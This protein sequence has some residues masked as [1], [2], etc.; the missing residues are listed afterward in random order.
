MADPFTSHSIRFQSWKIKACFRTSWAGYVEAMS[1]KILEYSRTVWAGILDNLSPS[2]LWPVPFLLV[3]LSAEPW[4]VTNDSPFWWLHF[5]CTV[6]WVLDV[7]CPYLSSPLVP[8]QS[9]AKHGCIICGG[10]VWD[11]SWARNPEWPQVTV[12]VG[13]LRFKLFSFSSFAV[14]FQLGMILKLTA[15]PL[16]TCRKVEFPASHPGAG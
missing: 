12:F 11:Y 9:I 8:L 13:K 3:L 4:L 10:W 6:S 15:S 16:N 1:M 2:F 14:N 7:G 5:S